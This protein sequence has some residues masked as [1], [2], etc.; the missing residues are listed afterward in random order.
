MHLQLLLL[1]RDEFLV[2]SRG[3]LVEGILFIFIFG[4]VDH[5]LRGINSVT[6]KR[7]LV[8]TAQD[9]TE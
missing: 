6:S 4:R 2:V 9:E 5:Y 7:G 8:V 3:F 1:Q